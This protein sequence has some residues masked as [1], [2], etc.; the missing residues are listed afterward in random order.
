MT[1]PAMNAPKNPAVP[2]DE[3]APWWRTGAAGW[4]LDL[5]SSVKL[6]IW[7][8]ALLF[9]YSSIGSAGIV[10][11]E[12][13]NILKAE[14]WAHDQMR[15]WRGLE[16]TEFEW[17]HWWPFDLM[18]ILISINIVVTT[19]RRIPFKPVNY[20]VWGIHAGI[21]VLDIGSFIYFGLKV[22]GDT[23]VARRKVVAE[24]DMPQ[25]DGS[26]RRERGSGHARSASASPR[27]GSARSA[28]TR[29]ATSR[30]CASSRRPKTSIRS[31]APGPSAAATTCSAVRSRRSTVLIPR[32]SRSASWSSASGAAASSR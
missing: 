23:P 26:S 5:F 20:G 13:W 15:Q 31:S 24:F 25:A 4:L 22:E 32:I 27:T 9:I 18:M 28:A 16:M 19:I 6:G 29:V 7:L 8:L 1:N 2:A 12:H 14:N 30:S 10:Y 17:F 21:I 11:P 3:A